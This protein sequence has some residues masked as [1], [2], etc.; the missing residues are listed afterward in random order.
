M[1]RLW[2]WGVL[3]LFAAL[4]AFALGQWLEAGAVRLELAEYRGEVERDRRQA[5]ESAG[6][7]LRR[8]RDEQ[9]EILDDEIQ[10]RKAAEADAVRAAAAGRGLQQQLAATRARFAA[11]S[12]DAAGEREAAGAA[13]MVLTELL[14]SCSERR[15]EL[16][17]FA[18]ESHAAGKLC[19]RLADAEVGEG[20]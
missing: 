11:T 4:G 19:E 1:S 6:R 2:G 15:R 8:L 5:A 16:A 17:Q 13:I 14:G 7:E 9:R 12:A 3:A 20:G 10:R 18:D